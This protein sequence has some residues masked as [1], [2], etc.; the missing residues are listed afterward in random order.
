MQRLKKKFFL[1]IKN[2][3]F[4]SLIFFYSSRQCKLFIGFID[5]LP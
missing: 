2:K 3:Y 5:Y 1:N 4:V